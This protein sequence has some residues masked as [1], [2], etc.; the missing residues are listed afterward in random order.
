MVFGQRGATEG[1]RSRPRLSA[2]ID[3]RVAPAEEQALRAHL[4]GCQA[5]A[6]ELRTL[7]L[8]VD[9]LGQLPRVPVPR[10]FLLEAPEPVPYRP[11]RWYYYLRNATGTVAA[12]LLA[13]LAF[14]Y[15]LQ[16]ALP[17]EMRSAAPRPP[18]TSAARPAAQPA[19]PVRSDQA[20]EA[21]PVRSDQA[22]EAAP[23]RS[24]QAKEAA[25]A[26]PEAATNVAP[27]ATT[28]TAGGRAGA[29]GPS[30]SPAG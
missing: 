7:R 12:L 11:L 5:C 20:K 1:E 25:K 14:T 30:P 10:S 9:M 4:A 24:D 16:A 2:H 28:K 22:K 23:V 27:E 21:A 6:A 13:L 19:A 26:A 8:T 17:V 18:A 15:V 29:S 3:R